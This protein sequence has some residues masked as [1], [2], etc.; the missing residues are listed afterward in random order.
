MCH[1][2]CC[3][4]GNQC[5]F[6]VTCE[7][8]KICALMEAF[9]LQLP[10]FKHCLFRWWWLYVEFPRPL[11]QTETVQHKHQQSAWCPS[12][13][14]VMQ[15]EVS[16]HCQWCV[17]SHRG[18]CVCLPRSRDPQSG[19]YIQLLPIH[20]LS[21]FSVLDTIEFKMCQRTQSV[22]PPLTHCLKYVQ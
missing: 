8:Y 19:Q 21:P 3:H 1:Q 6:S 4:H 12:S 13:A 20:H 22:K 15:T 9:S 5:R 17:Q 14:W 10:C 18:N 16:I 7:Q 11:P 2:T